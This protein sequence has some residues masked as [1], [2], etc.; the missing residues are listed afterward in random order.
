MKEENVK[1]VVNRGSKE[2]LVGTIVGSVVGVAT[3]LLVAPKSG[4]ELRA[5][6][7]DQANQAL[8]KT[9]Q[10]KESVYA[11]GQDLKQRTA[12]I[13]QVVSEQ[14]VQVVNKVKSLRPSTEELEAA[15]TTER[16]EVEEETIGEVPT[17][18]AE[19]QI[20]QEL[21][22]I[23]TEVNELEQSVEEVK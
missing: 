21:E 23:E 9:G 11:K 15:A 3:A 20:K 6:I 19:S 17:L 4:K 1:Q 5:S 10:V 22:N 18:E 16:T 7:Q 12:R 13:S 8:A 2:L 14:S